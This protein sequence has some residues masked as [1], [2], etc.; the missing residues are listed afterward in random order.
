MSNVPVYMQ[1]WFRPRGGGALRRDQALAD[2]LRSR[3]MK[4]AKDRS[5]ALRLVAW[6][7]RDRPEIEAFIRKQAK[8]TFGDETAEWQTPIVNGVYRTVRRL[9]MTYRTPPE[10]RYY[11]DDK[12]LTDQK[13]L[14]NIKTAF[15]RLDVDKRMQQLEQWMI[16]FNTAHLEPV[17]RRGR[18][19]YDFRLRPESLAIGAFDDYLDFD[20]FARSIEVSRLGEGTA[21]GFILWTED[22]YI[23]VREDGFVFPACDAGLDGSNPFSMQVWREKDLP[24]PVNRARK[25]EG[26]EYWGRYGCDI[27]DA[28]EQAAIQLGNLWE[29]V[30]LQGHGVPIFT[31]CNLKEGERKRVGPKDPI[32]VEKVQKDDVPPGLAF[33]KTEPDIEQ[34]RALIDWFVKQNGGSYFMPP[35]A[36]ATEE[37]E[38]SGFAK[39]VDSSELIEDR[40]QG[41]SDFRAIERQ[42]FEAS[43]AVWNANHPVKAEHIDPA[44]ELRVTFPEVEV[45]QTPQDEATT[46]ALEIQNNLASSVDYIMRKRKISDREEAKKL[47]LEIIAENADMKAALQKAIGAGAPG[48][49]FQDPN[50]DPNEDPNADPTMKQKPGFGGARNASRNQ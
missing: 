33:A 2:D 29:N 37:K 5:R 26:R 12:E 25:V 41:L 8:V 17:Y 40:E 18:I 43:V 32:V 44:I 34:T 45:L 9:A 21:K 15:R 38:M 22:E 39:L 42:N 36:Y 1:N 28:Y 24:I 7:E 10:R 50:A 3:W 14:E 23:F 20:Q 48:G 30:F 27:V 4:E 13:Q 11:I 16:L 35:S 19:D 31:N 49:D 47:A 46:I 6:Y